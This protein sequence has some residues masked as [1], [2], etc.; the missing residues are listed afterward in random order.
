MFRALGL[1]YRLEEQENEL[2]WWKEPSF[3]R[4]KTG[5][6]P[7]RTSASGR[8]ASLRGTL[9]F[10]CS[11]DTVFRKQNHVVVPLLTT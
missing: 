11:S 6:Q 7:Q 1:K 3:Y 9:A 4:Q 10:F 2:T 5:R 8:A